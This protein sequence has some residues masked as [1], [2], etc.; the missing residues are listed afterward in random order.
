M[1]N[2]GDKIKIRPEWQDTGDDRI[3]FTVVG[4]EE[5]GRVD[6]RAELG[7]PINPIS[8]VTVHMIEHK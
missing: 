3:E 1:Y 4:A 8:T 5:K 6:I 2:V 7:L